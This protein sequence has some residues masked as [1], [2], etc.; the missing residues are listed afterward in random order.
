[1]NTRA[2]LSRVG[3]L[4]SAQITFCEREANADGREEGT[5]RKENREETCACE[6]NDQRTAGASFLGHRGIEKG[7]GDFPQIEYRDDSLSIRRYARWICFSIT[8]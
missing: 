5:P 2:I 4:I 6:E 7:E 8:D 1:M 3:I